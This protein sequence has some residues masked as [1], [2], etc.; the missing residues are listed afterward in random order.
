MGSGLGWTHLKPG[1]I[2]AAAWAMHGLVV[3]LCHLGVPG[4]VQ[5]FVCVLAASSLGQGYGSMSSKLGYYESGGLALRLEL[6]NWWVGWEEWEP[7]R[8]PQQGD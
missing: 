8:S 3:F 7:S 5:A 1:L 6:V 2:E 4:T